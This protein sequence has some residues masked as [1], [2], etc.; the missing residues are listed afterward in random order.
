MHRPPA[1][2]NYQKKE[3]DQPMTPPMMMMRNR[4]TR[5]MTKYVQCLVSLRLSSHPSDEA[6][7]GIATK[8]TLAVVDLIYDVF[9]RETVHFVSRREPRA[10]AGSGL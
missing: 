8:P 3:E 5:P 9:L 2:T 10:A 6:A 1:S 4:K 7:E